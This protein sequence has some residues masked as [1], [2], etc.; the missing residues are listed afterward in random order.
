MKLAP[1]SAFRSAVFFEQPSP[2][3]KASVPCCRRSGVARLL[4][5][6]DGSDDLPAIWR[7][8]LRRSLP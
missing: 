6:V 7:T 3:H 2:A 8:P 5:N 1:G 4:Q